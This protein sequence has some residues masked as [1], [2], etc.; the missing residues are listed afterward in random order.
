MAALIIN[1]V[2]LFFLHII[3]IICLEHNS[4]ICYVTAQDDFKY[5]VWKYANY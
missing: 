1:E 5:T 4:L 3:I 2:L